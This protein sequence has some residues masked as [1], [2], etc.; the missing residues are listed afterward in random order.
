MLN[1]IARVIRQQ[2][3]YKIDHVRCHDTEV[4]FFASA[5]LTLSCDA[6]GQDHSHTLTRSLATLDLKLHSMVCYPQAGL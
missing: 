3:H 4:G 6:L 1:S 5:S 2:L